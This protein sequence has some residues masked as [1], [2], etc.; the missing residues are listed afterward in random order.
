MS[1]CR[2]RHRRLLTLFCR[3][4]RTRVFNVEDL[5]APSLV[6]V[7]DSSETAC[8]HNQYITDDNVVRVAQVAVLD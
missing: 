5:E 3:Y 4:T 6:H 1:C 7:Y 8:D 2:F